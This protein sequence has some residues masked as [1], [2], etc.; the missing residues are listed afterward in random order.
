MKIEKRHPPLRSESVCVKKGRIQSDRLP[1]ECVWQELEG[2]IYVTCKSCDA[3][4]DISRHG[5]DSTGE[6]NPCFICLNC[7]AHY[8]PVLEHWDGRNSYI[9]NY[10]GRVVRDK[11]PPERW[12]KKAM[13][14]GCCWYYYCPE[15]KGR[16]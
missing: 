2:R 10:C 4:N 9:C 8:F 3:I 6:V 15:H 12:K 5:I 11:E 14:C 1:H 7:G 13:Q 16:A